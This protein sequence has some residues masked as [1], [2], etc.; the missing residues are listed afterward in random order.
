MSME[1][2]IRTKL[3]A[4]LSPLSLAVE[5]QSHLHAGHAGDDGSGETH[6]RVQVVSESFR[7]QSRI[8]CHRMVHEILKN[9]M[10]SGI[11]ALVIDAK[12]P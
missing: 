12:A 3:A 5:N 8:A 9:E 2:A 11:H 1:E 10:K 7:G 4:A 6:F